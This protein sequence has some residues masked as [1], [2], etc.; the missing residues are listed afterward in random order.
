MF[1]H[2][3][4]VIVDKLLVY[5]LFKLAKESSN[6]NWPPPYDHS[7][8]L[9]HKATRQTNK[10]HVNWNI[11]KYASDCLFLTHSPHRV[12]KGALTRYGKITLES[13]HAWN[14]KILRWNLAWSM[15]FIFMVH[16][17]FYAFQLF[18]LWRHAWY[19]HHTSGYP[20]INISTVKGISR[21]EHRNVLWNNNCVDKLVDTI[22][23]FVCIRI[24]G[25]NSFYV[26]VLQMLNC[27]FCIQ[28]NLEFQF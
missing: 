22:N 7:C 14:L 12:P 25:V 26:T 3:V 6:V 4:L 8:W 1:K 27:I 10:Q 17:S 9:G 13:A 11:P 28:S 2:N 19:R 21:N 18:Y 20:V 5:W 16:L 23:G 15:S 24:V